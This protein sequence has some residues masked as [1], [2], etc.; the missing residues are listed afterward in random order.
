M[1]YTTITA[2]ISDQT[3]QLT[4]LPNLASGSIG[5]LRIQCHFCDLWDG[6]GKSAVFYKDKDT[7]YHSLIVDDIVTV[8]HEVL[9]E[10]GYFYFGVM[11]IADNTRTTEVL[12]ISVA[13]GAITS[14]SAESVEPSP[15]I[16]AQILAQYNE[17]SEKVQGFTNPEIADVKGLPEALAG[18]AT[19]D[20]NHDSVYAKFV[21][22][23]TSGSADDLNVS[24][25]L[26]DIRTNNEEL[27]NM[28][29]G[30][31]KTR[32]EN[33]CYII[34]LFLGS[35][36]SGASKVQIAVGY[37]W[38]TLLTRGYYGSNGWKPWNMMMSGI[39]HPYFAGTTLPSDGE[40]NQL[41]ILIP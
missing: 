39:L 9:A 16:Y 21:T 24:L 3:M 41:Y 2:H 13:Q 22:N 35:T 40:E 20:H 27:Y 25:T 1:S 4:N 19:S 26:L 6:Y 12:K 5:V 31:D 36:D 17:L 18:K 23:I 8:P 32:G 30:G 37:T 10:A 33:Y 28:L 38:G 7:V 14:A 15:D 34:T 29:L 11:G